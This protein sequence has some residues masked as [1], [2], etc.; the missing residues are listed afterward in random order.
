MVG[1]VCVAR[2]DRVRQA[3]CATQLVLWNDGRGPMLCHTNTLGTVD[4]LKHIWRVIMMPQRRR[5]YETWAQGA[6]VQIQK[7]ARGLPY[8]CGEMKSHGN[9]G[10]NT[11]SGIQYVL[12]IFQNAFRIIHTH[13][14][15]SPQAGKQWNACSASLSA[16]DGRSVVF[17]PTTHQFISGTSNSLPAYDGLQ[18]S[19]E[20]PA[21]KDSRAS[22]E[23]LCFCSRNRR[24]YEGV[25]ADL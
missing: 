5:G 16:R 14:P 22:T 7:S 1:C 20:P 19:V 21:T 15:F 9:L 25:A 6:S 10:T 12:S 2:A 24:F 4:R 11:K 23:T 13:S 17:P 3:E 8:H 18:T